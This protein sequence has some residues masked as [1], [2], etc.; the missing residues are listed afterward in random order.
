MGGS[1]PF[2]ATRILFTLV[3]TFTNSC[4]YND[5]LPGREAAGDRTD[6]SHTKWRKSKF[7]SQTRNRMTVDGRRTDGADGGPINRNVAFR[8]FLLAGEI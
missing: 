7:G 8:G 1:Q 6:C 2:R 5:A 3:H 4:T